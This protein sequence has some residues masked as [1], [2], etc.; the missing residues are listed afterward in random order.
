MIIDPYLFIQNVVVN[1]I[2]G[3]IDGLEDKAVYRLCTASHG[4]RRMC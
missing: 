4:Y 2:F 3:A 1:I